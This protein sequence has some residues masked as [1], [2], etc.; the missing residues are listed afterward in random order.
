MASKVRIS[1]LAMA[2][3]LAGAA[4]PPSETPPFA[5]TAWL[6]DYAA[7]KAGMEDGYA[8]LAWFG[9]P[10][11]G[12]DLPA[13]DR[14]T[15]KA[16]EQADS[17]EEARLALGNFIASFHDGHL[18]QLPFLT[19]PLATPSA[20]PPKRDLA[21][22]DAGEGC[23]ALGYADRSQA[24]FSLPF[25]S[26]PGFVMHADGVGSAV[27]AG[28]VAVGGR[29]IGIVRLKNFS[30]QQ[31]PSAC[32]RAWPASDAKTRND[33][34]AFEKRVTRFW[35]EALAAQLRRFEAEGVAAVLVDVGANSGGDE[36]ADWAARLFTARP[37]VSARLLMAAAKPATDYFDEQ[38]AALKAAPGAQAGAG[39]A[40]FEAR[41][42]L[43]ATRHCDMAWVWR[44][45]RPWGRSEC[46][47]LLD[48]GWASGAFNYL[49][50]G[51]VGDPRVAAL[52]YWPAQVER[53]RGSW[54]GATYLLTGATSYSAAEMF[55]A[56]MK[57]NGV[58]RT[59]G[60]RTGGDGCGFMAEAEPLVLPHSRLRYRMPNCIRLR[61]DGTD[62]VAGIAPDL[63][64]LPTQGE[65]TRAR[66]MRVLTTLVGDLE[67]PRARTGR[68]VLP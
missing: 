9:S 8:N 30:R 7:L 67:A 19:A 4:A 27:R 48:A 60:T 24:A 51:S 1:M 37:V 62:E 68:P 22:V 3:W 35:F 40:A 54:R 13:L 11:G 20:E 21:H 61:R 49:A 64:V 28:I 41:K 53:W 32:L 14:R 34:E 36:S 31:Y 39:A 45:R 6:E 46:S 5:R 59:I 43:V 25:E 66:A 16:L 56:V 63:L 42:P 47:R 12:V 17:D 52:L 33:P 57:D 58:A 55:A 15:T 23:A 38:I 44:E 10:E 65:S 29:R 50:P 2:A 18:S 26:L